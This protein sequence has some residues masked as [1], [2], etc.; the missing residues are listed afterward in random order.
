MKPR[1]L[2]GLIIAL[3]LITGC[4]GS[5]RTQVIVGTLELPSG[6]TGIVRISVLNPPDVKTIQVGPGGFLT[7]NPAVIQVAGLTGVN[8]FTVFGS[9]INNLMGWV[10]FVASFSGGSIRPI[11]A[12]G[13][14]VLQ[15]P[16]IEMSVQAIGSVGAQTALTITAIDLFTD[17]VGQ[18]IPLGPPIAGQVVIVAP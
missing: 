16:I 11:V 3:G 18:P 6:G 2:V 7:F 15:I 12:P 5:Y 9:T 13:L 4:E 14:G 1:V 10:Q 17:R 8:G